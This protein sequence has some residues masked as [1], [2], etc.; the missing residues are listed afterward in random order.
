M[1]YI[2]SQRRSIAGDKIKNAKK[3]YE[4]LVRRLE[5]EGT[6]AWLADAMVKAK[7]R[8]RMMGLA[9]LIKN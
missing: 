3:T 5:H 6:T 1:I 9:S 4:K 2:V 8:L 7:A